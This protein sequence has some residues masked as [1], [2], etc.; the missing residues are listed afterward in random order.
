MKR[1]LVLFFTSLSLLIIALGAGAET[2]SG[3]ITVSETWSGE[4]MLTG[5]VVVAGG[6]TLTILPGTIV[7]AQ[8]DAD[9]QESGVDETLIE[10][11]IEGGILDASGTE[12]EH[13]TF[14]SEGKW[15]GI[16]NV[17][18]ILT[19]KY[20]DQSAGVIGL[21]V[22]GSV[23]KAVENCSFTGNSDYGASLK[24]SSKF[25]GCR[26]EG[27]TNSGIYCE[28]GVR[29]ENCEINFNGGYGISGSGTTMIDRCNITFNSD[30]GID[31]E[32]TTTIE[33][34][35]ITFNGGMGVDVNSTVTVTGS[36]I[37]DNGDAG[38]NVSGGM[39]L[40]ESGYMTNTATIADCKISNNAGVGVSVI[41][42]ADRDHHN[43]NTLTIS[44]CVITQN[45]GVGL[46][47]SG[48]A[49]AWGASSHTYS[50]YN[51]AVVRNCTITENRGAGL[52][53]S[54]NASSYFDHHRYN[55]KTVTLS[56]STI[57]DNLRAGVEVV[58]SIISSWNE[59]NTSINRC[60][61]KEN[62]GDGVYNQGY[63]S[64]ADSEIT[65]NAGAGVSPCGIDGFNRNLVAG[66][67]VGICILDSAAEAI[68][69]ITLNDIF[70]N[71]T[72][73]LENRSSVEV[74]ADDNYWGNPT[75]AELQGETA[76]LTRIFDQQD[77][78]DVGVVTI[79]TYLTKRVTDLPHDDESQ[80]LPTLTVSVELSPG[81]NIISLPLNSTPSYTASML[82][83]KLESTIVIRAEDS[84]FEA[85]VSDGQ[86]GSDFPIE[87]GKGYIVNPTTAQT[88]TVTGKPW[89]TGSA[90]PPANRLTGPWAFVVAGRIDG[91]I[92]MGGQI[93]ATNLRTGEQIIA[94]ISPSGD[95]TAVFVDMSR[96]SVVS[97]GDEIVT[98]IMGA[99]GFPLTGARRHIISQKHIAN[100]YL[101]TRISATPEKPKLLQN[102]PNPFN[103]ETWIPFQLSEDSSVRVDIYN[104]SGHLIRRLNLGYRSTGWHISREQAVYW[105]GK[106]SAGESVA[107]GIYF[108]K[109]QA[110]D[111]VAAGKMIAVK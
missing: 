15:Y 72:Y 65:D 86:I 29:A 89:T 54:G 45:G 37:T 9:D 10:I 98:Q 90:A 77:N 108:Y 28:N 24:S 14:T 56:E 91:Q 46:Q 67:D 73:E 5:D 21:S 109:L 30:T 55:Y 20:C 101:L 48:N 1:I 44:D 59:N 63:I 8:P 60:E 79:S 19:L 16:R 74:V 68:K 39:K 26:F 12:S 58:G 34:C 40:D 50:C 27:N 17:M 87:M 64:I 69:G 75:T 80:G 105:D 23:P 31:M 111:F 110:G 81:T 100:A 25:V 76:N 49:S 99:G 70:D 92:P 103:P 51:T 35:T 41:N 96:R 36:T 11:I 104:L 97:A 2:T 85:Y 42:N 3:V 93:F 53:L 71:K 32:G 102:Y 38:I 84:S 43:R 52:R 6:A 4:V 62:S 95:F 13:I 61:I 106:N 83:R 94:S 78:P 82:A 47:V 107:S 22:E 57:T 18:G 88:F 33:D 7:K 66:N